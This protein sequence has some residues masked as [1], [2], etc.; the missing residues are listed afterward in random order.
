MDKGVPE[1]EQKH[2][3]NKEPLP[4]LMWGT[5]SLLYFLEGFLIAVDHGC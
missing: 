3:Q 5:E 1:R 4:L 2:S